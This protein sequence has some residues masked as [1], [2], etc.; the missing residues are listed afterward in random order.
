MR[1]VLDILNDRIE[2]F[3]IGEMTDWR[4]GFIDGINF[5]KKAINE[6]IDTLIT[7]NEDY[8]IIMYENGDRYFPYIE[9]MRL[10]K[11]SEGKVRNS[12]CFSRNMN[13]NKFNTKIPDLVLASKE[14]IRSR[15]F[16][17]EEEAKNS[18]NK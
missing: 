8:Y 13:A 17:T 15:V 7:P 18:I 6:N 10:Y 5:S 14:G 16:F 3:N 4:R 11:I 2:K 9:K 12:Y 1:E